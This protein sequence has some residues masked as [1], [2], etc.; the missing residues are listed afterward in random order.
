MILSFPAHPFIL[1]IIYFSCLFRFDD[2][3]LRLRSEIKVPVQHANRECGY[4]YALL[5]MENTLTYEEIVQ[6]RSYGEGVMNRC[7]VIGKEYTAGKS[8]LGK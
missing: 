8:K 2:K 1:C 7:L 4:K 5:N 3:L 6:F